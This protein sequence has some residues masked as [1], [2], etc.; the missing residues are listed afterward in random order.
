MIKIL[1]DFLPFQ[2]QF[3]NGGALY[4]KRILTELSKHEDVEI[5]GVCLNKSKLNNILYD[6]ERIKVFQVIEFRD[7]DY[8]NDYIE[9]NKIQSFFIGIAQRY[10]NID[11]T[12]IKCNIYLVCHDLGDFSMMNSGA[13]NDIDRYLLHLRIN[14]E[15]YIKLRLIKKFLKNLKDNKTLFLHRINKN[16]LIKKLG[17]SN[18]SNLIKKNNVYLITVSEYSKNSI[19]YYFDDIANKISV[20]YPP[21]EINEHNLINVNLD[22]LNNKP[23]FLLL[24]TD[25]YNKNL[26]IF[27]HVFN[28]WNQIH[29]DNFACIFVGIDY[30]N[31]KNAKCFK[32]LKEDELIY[33]LKNCYALIYPSLSEGFGS[34]PIECM[35]YGKPVI[36]AFDTSIPEVCKE[37][38]LFFNPLY[39]ED[40]FYKQNL[41]VE[42]YNKYSQLSKKRYLEISKKQIEDLDNMIMF[43]KRGDKYE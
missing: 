13:Y 3:I 31:M 27:Y 40:L 9:Q 20:F 38:A 8:I 34:P 15:K 2:D 5:I 12:N 24:S 21:E 39:E 37:G 22:E 43:I 1:F 41:L 17:Y 4:T 25:R 30:I 10:N 32:Y 29:N 26:F 7:V 16:K 28:K 18:F 42:N 6:I 19:L 14:N 33:L 23:Y 11:L 36:A 35:K